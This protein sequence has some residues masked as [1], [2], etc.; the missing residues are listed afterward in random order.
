VTLLV[1]G[2]AKIVGF[3]EEN[4]FLDWILE[5]YLRN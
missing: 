2:E 1:W 3:D 5:G 4:S